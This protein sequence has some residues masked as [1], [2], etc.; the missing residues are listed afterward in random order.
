M[1]RGHDEWLTEGG[2]DLHDG[3][4]RSWGLDSEDGGPDFSLKTLVMHFH[5]TP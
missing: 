3:A 4:E 2:S 5:K 1:L